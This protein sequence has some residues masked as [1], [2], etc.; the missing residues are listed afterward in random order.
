[1]KIKRT[2]GYILIAV[3]LALIIFFVRLL[4]FALSEAGKL[5]LKENNAS[6]AE[7]AFGTLIA[8]TILLTFVTYR[9]LIRSGTA[10]NMQ[11]SHVA[12]R[13]VASVKSRVL[14]TLIDGIVTLPLA[15]GGYLVSAGN[16]KLMLAFL[17]I[18]HLLFFYD[19]TF[20][21]L[22]GQT[23]GK[24]VLGIRVFTMTGEKLSFT[25][26]AVRISLYAA[27]GLIS[28]I[29]LGNNFPEIQANGVLAL[30]YAEILEKLDRDSFAYALSG[31][32][33][34]GLAIVDIIVLLFHPQRRA[35]HDLMSRTIVL[36]A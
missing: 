23:I 15:F 22:T 14:A 28:L 4:H 10:S 13:A 20:D 7:L 29:I 27:S 17:C 2:I 25:Q 11:E 31:H 5:A 30:N 19:F 8:I 6:D 16:P 18:T 34:L 12:G 32:A 26:A 21:W 24:K 3:E 36:K 33:L 1:M 9:Y 35:L